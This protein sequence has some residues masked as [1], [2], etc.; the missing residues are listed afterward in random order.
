MSQLTKRQ[1]GKLENI[2]YHLKRAKR[3]LDATNVRVCRVDRM[4][5]TTLHYT[6]AARP[7]ESLYSVDKY[8]GS[9]LCGLQDAEEQLL[10]ILYPP[11]V[12]VEP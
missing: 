10:A 12:E 4:A 1:I 2:L 5:T 7:D 11:T 6:C 9:D 8:I 3:Y